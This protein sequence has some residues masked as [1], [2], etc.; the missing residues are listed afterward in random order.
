MLK[1][2]QMLIVMK[3]V[4]IPTVK[5]PKMFNGTNL[6]FEAKRNLERK[7]QEYAVKGERDCI[8]RIRKLSA[9]ESPF[10]LLCSRDKKK[11]K[12]IIT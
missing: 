1:R 3:E 5:S 10:F 2:N 4:N 9:N 6:D 12:S 7:C 11:L 8:S